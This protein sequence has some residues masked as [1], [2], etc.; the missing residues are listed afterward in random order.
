MGHVFCG[1]ASDDISKMEN[2]SVMGV[3][4]NSSPKNASTKYYHR[5]PSSF[6]RPWY[7]PFPV[8]VTPRKQSNRN[9]RMNFSR[10]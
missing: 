2:S 5:I 7:K 4:S 1:G 9:S 10:P 3:W 6:A 8:S